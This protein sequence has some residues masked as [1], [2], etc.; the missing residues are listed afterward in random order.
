M[1]LLK[2]KQTRFTE[3]V[4]TAGKPEVYTLWLE[5]KKD[6]KFQTLLRNNRV[7]TVLSTEGGSDFGIV[8]FQKR[9]G[10]RFLVFEKPLKR[11]VDHRVIG[12]KW[13]LVK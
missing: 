3:L 2:T 13:E 12:I 11:F 1:K 9:P 5:P 4:D 8:G 6:K 10:A 7:M